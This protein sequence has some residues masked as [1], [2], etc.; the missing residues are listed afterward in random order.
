MGAS[1]TTVNPSS[2]P[3]Y[4]AKAGLPQGNTAEYVAEGTITDMT[5]VKVTTAAPGA[6]GP[7]GIP[8]VVIPNA[9]AK[10]KIESVKKYEPP[11]Q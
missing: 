5:D 10:A 6:Q 4:A 2:T 7:G 3:D 1:W 11:I 9:K 8:E